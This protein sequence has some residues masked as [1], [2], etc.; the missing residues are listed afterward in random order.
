LPPEILPKSI[1]DEP[2]EKAY[3]YDRESLEKGV[4]ARSEA[5]RQSRAKTEEVTPFG[6]AMTCKEI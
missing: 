5:T 3:G 4:I 2:D 1:L 6:L